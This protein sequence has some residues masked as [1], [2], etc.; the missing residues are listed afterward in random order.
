MAKNLRTKSSLGKARYNSPPL[1]SMDCLNQPGEDAFYR[2]NE[3]LMK[4]T[5]VSTFLASVLFKNRDTEKIKKHVKEIGKGFSD[6]KF[7]DLLKTQ[8]NLNYRR[9]ADDLKPILQILNIPEEHAKL[10]LMDIKK[11]QF[12]L[13][14]DI[15][16][17]YLVGIHDSKRNITRILKLYD[18]KT[19]ELKMLSDLKKDGFTFIE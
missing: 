6:E 18:A 4:E 2:V 11:T 13:P 12:E 16:A 17:N 7:K 9:L 19:V 14:E 10:F 8:S 15:N 5:G 3:N 1:F